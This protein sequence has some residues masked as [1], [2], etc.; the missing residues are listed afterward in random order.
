VGRSE[1]TAARGLCVFGLT[2]SVYTRI[3]RLV[4]EEKG[5][6]YV[7]EEV[8]IF[9]AAGLPADHVARHPFGRIPVLQHDDFLL[10]ET[11]AIARYVDEVLPGPALQPAGTRARAR[12]NQLV[13]LLDAYAYRPMVW[14]VFVERVL[15]PREGRAPDSA[16][17]SRALDA[18]RCC[19]H[20]IDRLRERSAFLAGDDVTLAD[21][22]AFPMLRYLELAHEGKALIAMI[23]RMQEWMERMSARRS[24][25]RTKG[26]YES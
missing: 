11:T 13:A 3:A 5:A 12:M 22:H 9:G 6:D 18:A 7:L 4:L 23:P 8:E 16:V 25:E 15:A 10:Y 1:L 19:L 26:P 2:R 24:A 20:E 21:L 14:G 17:I